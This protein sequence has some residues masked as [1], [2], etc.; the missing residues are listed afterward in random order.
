MVDETNGKVK[1]PSGWTQT[2]SII[3]TLLLMFVVFVRYLSKM[4]SRIDIVEIK[5]QILNESGTSIAKS[6]QQN[7]FK[8]SAA[9][10][11]LMKGQAEISDNIKY[12]QSDIKLLASKANRLNN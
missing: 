8:L 10:E 3:I 7:I 1:V 4:E 6:N 12:I 9:F 11:G 5:Y 2:L